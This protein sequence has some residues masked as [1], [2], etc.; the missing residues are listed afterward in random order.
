MKGK[1][2][3]TAFSY[4][5]VGKLQCCLADNGEQYEGDLDQV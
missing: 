5:L 2:S 1:K 3:R 4:D